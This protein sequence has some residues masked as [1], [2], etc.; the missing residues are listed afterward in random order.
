MKKQFLFATINL[1]L[2]TNFSSTV[3]AKGSAEVKAVAVNTEKSGIE[4]IGK[5]TRRMIWLAILYIER[6]VIINIFALKPIYRI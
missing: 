6:I 5:K 3:F 4:W 1:S 2:I